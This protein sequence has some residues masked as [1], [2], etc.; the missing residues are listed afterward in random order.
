MITNDKV[1]EIFCII[2]EFDK[3]LSAELAK[4]LRLKSQPA[5][6]IL[7]I[8]LHLLVDSLKTEK[9]TQQGGFFVDIFSSIKP[10]RILC[11]SN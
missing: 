9:A 3:N 4:N 6:A 5:S 8:I 1:T 10:N 2:D 11:R 7:R